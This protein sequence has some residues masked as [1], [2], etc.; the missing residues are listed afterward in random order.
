MFLSSIA[1]STAS[2]ASRTSFLAADSPAFCA[3]RGCAPTGIVKLQDS[4]TANTSRS[5][6]RIAIGSLT[7]IF[8]LDLCLAHRT[9]PP[10]FATRADSQ[11][12]CEVLAAKSLE[13]PY[14]KL[15]HTPWFESRYLDTRRVAP[16]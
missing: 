15:A 3:G 13:T 10:R 1:R 9:L 7:R 2:L 14:L 5:G 8:D 4:I 12:N 11:Q 16:I 6:V